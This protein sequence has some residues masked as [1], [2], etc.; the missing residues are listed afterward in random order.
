MFPFSYILFIIQKIR[1]VIPERRLI[2]DY[3]YLRSPTECPPVP[4]L[5]A[6][7]PAAIIA[8]NTAII[9]NMLTLGINA[10]VV[11][12][13]FLQTLVVVEFARV[14][15]PLINTEPMSMAA[16]VKPMIRMMIPLMLGSPRLDLNFRF[17]VMHLP[18][19][20]LE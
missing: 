5:K 6:A 11:A 2:R 8:S 10:F 4:S 12:S 18:I 20:S 17:R 9:M 15:T 13:Q 7:R 3:F 19:P 16:I 14:P 1:D